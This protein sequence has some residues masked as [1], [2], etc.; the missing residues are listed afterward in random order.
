MP[1]KETER[2][3]GERSHH[4]H[5]HCT[6]PC[7][8][9]LSQPTTNMLAQDTSPKALG[10]FNLASAELPKHALCVTWPLVHFEQL[11]FGFL[12]CVRHLHTE[13]WR[14][15]IEENMEVFLLSWTAWSNV[16]RW[17]K[18]KLKWGSLNFVPWLP[19]KWMKL[20]L[21]LFKRQ[22]VRMSDP[23]LESRWRLLV[24]L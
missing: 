19:V 23:E 12:L 22:R 16:C 8:L 1:G 3:L 9:R 7:R 17:D 11:I 14:Y 2:H 21:S 18:I 4:F 20:V 5:R 15:S 6:Q 24:V 13:G 10:P